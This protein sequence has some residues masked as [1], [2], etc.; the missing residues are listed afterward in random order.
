MDLLGVFAGAVYAA[1]LRINPLGISH[2]CHAFEHIRQVAVAAQLS[3]DEGGASS[4]QEPGEVERRHETAL[5]RRPS[6]TS[7]FSHLVGVIH[8]T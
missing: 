3:R 5:S 2:A 1:A 7:P 6:C 8:L 4:E